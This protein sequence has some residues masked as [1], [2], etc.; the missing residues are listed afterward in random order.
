MSNGTGGSQSIDTSF[1]F[2]DKMP[3]VVELHVH[4]QLQVQTCTR[5]LM[6]SI[7]L[8]KQTQANIKGHTHPASQHI[9]LGRINPELFHWHTHTKTAERRKKEKESE[10]NAFQYYTADPFLPDIWH[11]VSYHSCQ[12][13]CFLHSAKR[14]MWNNAWKGGREKGKME[15]RELS[16]THSGDLWGRRGA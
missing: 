6:Y 10:C 5:L 13:K 4:T 2:L 9:T 7:C 16:W 3:F 14:G 8:R 11:L 1:V 15:K 12:N